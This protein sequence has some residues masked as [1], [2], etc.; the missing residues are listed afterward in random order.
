[1]KA[2][3]RPLWIQVLL[4]FLIP[5]AGMAMGVGVTFLSGINQT[6]YRDLVVNLF[7][8]TAC[9]ALLPVFNFSRDDLGLKVIHEKIR[10]HVLISLAIIGLYLLFYIFVIRISGLKQFSASTAWGLLTYLVV[11]LAEELYFRGML[12]GFFEKRFSA[13]TALIVTSLLFG[14]FHARQGLTGIVSRTFTGWLWGSVRYSS[15]MIFL[16]IFPI[17]FA[18]NATW[19]LFEGSWNN[20]PVWAIYAL[21]T[22]EFLLGLAIVTTHHRRYKPKVDTQMS[23]LS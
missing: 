7:Y 4:L 10:W 23:Q 6:N 15:G 2:T 8:L 16:L 21:P 22:I 18:Y 13:R 12:Y 5:I 14:L 3:T 9:L 1:M 20:P 19:L 11:I 17:H